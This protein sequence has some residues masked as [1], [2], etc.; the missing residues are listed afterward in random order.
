[1]TPNLDL[2][3]GPILEDLEKA[4]GAGLSTGAVGSFFIAGLVSAVRPVDVLKVS[5]YGGLLLGVFLVAI[6][7]FSR[8]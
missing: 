1:V 2:F 5:S 3:H 4:A 6:V 8:F 7:F